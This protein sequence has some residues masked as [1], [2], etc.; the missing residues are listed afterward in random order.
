M[1]S[2]ASVAKSIRKIKPHSRRY[3][4]KQKPTNTQRP[5]CLS[6]YFSHL[7]VCI[8]LAMVRSSLSVWPLLCKCETLL[9]NDFIHM[10]PQSLRCKDTFKNTPELVEPYA[11][12]WDLTRCTATSIQFLFACL[13]AIHLVPTICGSQLE[14][15]TRRLGAEILHALFKRMQ[16]PACSTPTHLRRNIHCIAF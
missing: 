10:D 3:E 13:N 6:G 15:C 11:A 9:Q 16:A 14:K 1:C 12:L 2:L 4:I 7:I 5:S 8:P